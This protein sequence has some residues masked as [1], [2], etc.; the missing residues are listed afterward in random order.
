MVSPHNPFVVYHGMQYLFRSMDRGETWE[1]ISPDLTCNNPEEQGDLPYAISFQT[2]T[3]ISESPFQFGLIYVGTDDGRVHVTRDGGNCW[4]DITEGLPHKKHVSRIIASAY[5]KGTVYLSL[6]GKRDDDFVAYLYKSTDYGQS[7]ID[8][9]SNIPCGP[10]NVI[11]ED[12][13]NGKVLYV[14]TDLGVYVTT[15]GGQTWHVLGSGLPSTFV[16]DLVV[17]P[18]DNILVAAT[19]GRGMWIIDDVSSVQNF[20]SPPSS[21]KTLPP[22]TMGCG[23]TGTAASLPIWMEYLHPSR[24]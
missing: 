3:S 23:W 21:P 20:G 15:D 9:K 11:K 18:R 2:I 13:K 24:F 1:K 16:H 19:H 10:I 5:D 7:W 17:H 12:P 22:S 8:I 14:G 4:T 6:N